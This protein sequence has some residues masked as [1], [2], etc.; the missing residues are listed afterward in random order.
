MKA[1]TIFFSLIFLLVA[2]ALGNIPRGTVSSPPSSY[3]VTINNFNANGPGFFN[4]ITHFL[5]D[6]SA[7][8]DSH[9]GNIMQIGST[10]WLYSTA[11]ACGFNWNI[12]GPFCGF[13]VYSSTDLINWT[14]RGQPFDP[15]TGPWQT[16]C[17][18]GGLGCFEMRGVYNAANN[19]Y[20]LWFQGPQS[21]PNFPQNYAVFVCSTPYSGCVQQASPTHLQHASAITQLG[22][23][24]DTTGIAYAAYNSQSS[25]PNGL[26]VDQLNSTYTDST[27]TGVGPLAS[28]N[29]EASSMFMSGGY[30]FVVYGTLCAYCSASPSY[31]VSA[32]SPLGTYSSPTMI[33]SDSC[34]GQPAAIFSVTGGPNVANVYKVDKWVNGDGNQS[35]AN[36]YYEAL[37]T[38]G[39]TLAPMTCSDTMTVQIPTAP[40]SEP[41]IPPGTPDQQDWCDCYYSFNELTS[42]EWYLQTFIPTATTLSKIIIP[43]QQYSA[44]GNM[45]VS[46]VT[47]DGSNNPVTTLGTVTINSATLSWASVMT[48]LTYNL[49]G[50][51]LGATYAIEIKGPSGGLAGSAFYDGPTSTYPAGLFRF[52]TNS[53]SSWSTVANRALMFAT[54]P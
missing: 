42:S 3:S 12:A 6:G 27:G 41:P 48:D 2:S 10:F 51:T 24:V 11:N 26:F 1:I 16:L 15:N 18:T 13:N 52:T 47:V 9:D 28:G 37:S 40:G 4:S 30:Y 39:P 21:T 29:V 43:L 45:T 20:V 54:Y 31:Y 50:L 38:S 34:G 5:T 49:S 22:I 19:N 17:G 46:I 44:S 8:L 7:A 14:F 36:T 25:G 33:S 53:G 32:S 23:M 35:I